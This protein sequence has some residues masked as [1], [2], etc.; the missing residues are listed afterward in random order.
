MVEE[1]I[2]KLLEAAALAL[3]LVITRYLVPYLRSRVGQENLEL[4]IAW[5]G[6]FVAAAEKLFVGKG[7]GEE[8]KEKVTA[9][10]SDKM[11]EL[12]LK[13]SEGDLDSIIEEAVYLLTSE[14]NANEHTSI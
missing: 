14:H 9:Q 4:A 10:L 1:I 2:L 11:N 13:I 8:K 3:V 12:G 7:R 5:A 6:T